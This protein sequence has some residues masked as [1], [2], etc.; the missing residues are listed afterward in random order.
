[1]PFFMS[2]MLVPTIAALKA[3]SSFNSSVYSN[4]SAGGGDVGG[5]N[6]GLNG[7]GGGPGLKCVLVAG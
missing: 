6:L 4:S 3:W 5:G 2:S 7:G 1:M